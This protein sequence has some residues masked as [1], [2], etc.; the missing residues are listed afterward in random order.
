MSSSHFADEPSQLPIE[1]LRG[2]T[3]VSDEVS[4]D[5]AARGGLLSCSSLTFQSCT[6]ATPTARRSLLSLAADRDTSLPVG[7][8]Y[9]SC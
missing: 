1:C 9:E 3:Y 7:S 2:L 8:E 6:S 5:E 4:V